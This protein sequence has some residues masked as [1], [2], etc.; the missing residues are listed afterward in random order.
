MCAS[1]PVFLWVLHKCIIELRNLYRIIDTNYIKFPLSISILLDE[2]LSEFS[3]L[4]V[5]PNIYLAYYLKFRD[6]LAAKIA[7]FTSH[8]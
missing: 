7:L 5:L 6:T 4:P 8:G 3:Y 1:N 2:I